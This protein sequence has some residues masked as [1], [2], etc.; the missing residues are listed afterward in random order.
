[1]VLYQYLKGR[2]SPAAWEEEARLNEAMQWLGCGYTPA[3]RTWYDFR[4]RVGPV[5]ESMHTELVQ[6]AIAQGHLNPTT[7][8]LDGTS[9]AA[10]ASRHR[11]VTQSTLIKRRAL[12][13]SLIE[14]AAPSSDAPPKWVPTTPRGRLD[15]AGRMEAAAEVLAER[16]AQNTAKPVEK[17][18]DPKKICVSLTDPIAPLGR[19]KL[20]TYRPMYTVQTMVDPVSHLTISYMCEPKASDSA[21]L[22][23]M[24]DKTQ[25]IA[26]GRLKMV[27]ADGS[28]CS[29][30]DLRDAAERGIDLL[31][32]PSISS[33][34]RQSKSRSGEIQFP[35][36]M[37]RFDAESNSYECPEGHRLVYKDREKKA[38]AN[39]RSLY[40]SR[41]QC[42]AALCKAC[43]GAD[44]C[45]SGKGPR[46]IKRTEGE[47]LMEAQRE[48]MAT[49]EARAS[50]RLRG[51]A[52]ELGFGDAK[53]NRRVNR[54]HGRGLLRARCETG[55][56]ILAQS[57][58]RLGNIIR[59][60]E[61]PCEC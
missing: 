22:A 18:K 31:A 61:N 38:R 1:M 7:A 48:K 42:A 27:L 39:D 57:L 15:L 44:R 6:R 40:Q 24:I 35:R 23:P 51:Q 12:L 33:S 37:F 32:P 53:G 25:K 45:L 58:L 13:A 14:G 17:R 43:P 3:R 55:L 26:G 5:I 4:D 36:E 9:M 46:I 11:M 56:L 29:I 8:A 19:D 50:Y 34:S 10:C 20:G 54:F 59:H 2:Q 47:E 52:V 60:A 16:I 30:L 21:M 28:Y 41:Y 49:D